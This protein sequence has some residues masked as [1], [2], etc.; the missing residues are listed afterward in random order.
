MKLFY[1]YTH[2]C[3]YFGGAMKKKSSL[4]KFDI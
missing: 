4:I 2:E 1:F 3:K